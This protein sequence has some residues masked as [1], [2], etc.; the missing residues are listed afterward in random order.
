MR[1]LVFALASLF[2][3]ILSEAQ[4]PPSGDRIARAK[5]LYVISSQAG[6]IEGDRI[7]FKNVPAVV[8]FSDRPERIAGHMTLQ[9]FVGIW[10][11]EPSGLMKTPP[12]ATL[13]VIG[14]ADAGNVEMKLSDPIA[15]DK[16]TL[17]FKVQFLKSKTPQSFGKSS[18]FIDEVGA[19][20]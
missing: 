7:V 1:Y 17:S 13:S 15:K 20:R 11:Y 8:Y 5:F 10:K 6:S 9:D 12:T 3:P 16:D 14:L 4:Q 18:L 2:L 19:I